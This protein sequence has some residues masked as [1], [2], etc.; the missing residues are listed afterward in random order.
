MECAVPFQRFEPTKCVLGPRQQ[1]KRYPAAEYISVSYKDSLLEMPSVQ[2]VTPWLSKPN[3]FHCS[4]S[5]DLGWMASD[6]AFFQK[7]K[8]LHEHIRLGLSSN[9]RIKLNPNPYLL[10]VY[11]DRN[12][13]KIISLPAGKEMELDD[14]LLRN[15]NQQYKLCI[16]LAGIHLQHGNANYRFKCVGIVTKSG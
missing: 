14:S 12:K 7:L 4:E 16:R 9:H 2:I 6:N 11:V 8:I 15:P 13:T 3:D 10:S 1:N 5:C